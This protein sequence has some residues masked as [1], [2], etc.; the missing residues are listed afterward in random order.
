MVLEK[1]VREETL[2]SFQKAL[3]AMAEMEANLDNMMA[4]VGVEGHHRCYRSSLVLSSPV[5]PK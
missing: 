5:E 2:S 1:A 4:V 3:R